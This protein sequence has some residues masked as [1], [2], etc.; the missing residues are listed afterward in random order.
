MLTCVIS[1]TISHQKCNHFM[2]WEIWA[3]SYEF[4]Q[5]HSYNLVQLS[6]AQVTLG[7]GAK[8]QRCIF[9]VIVHFLMIHST[10]FYFKI[11]TTVYDIK[12]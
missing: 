9:P 1:N 2:R 11:A 8:F 6:F 7:L 12:L 4:I 5:S 10:Q 3:N